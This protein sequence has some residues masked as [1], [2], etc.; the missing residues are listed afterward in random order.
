MESVG[1]V[2]EA[3]AEARTPATRMKTAMP[4]TTIAGPRRDM[5]WKTR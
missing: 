3:K 5:G 2:P 4:S 1:S